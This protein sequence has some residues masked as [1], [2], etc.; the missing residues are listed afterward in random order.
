MAHHV[1]PWW[2]GYW[3]VNPLRRLIENPDALFG[4]LV[5]EGMVVVEPGCG[6]GFFTLSLARLAGPSGRIIA[7]DLQPRML[8]G[9]R[10]R[11]RR[12]RLAD[13][14]EARL[15]TS[16]DLGLSDLAGVA[17]LV[18]AIHVIHEVPDAAGFLGQLRGVLREGGRLLIVEPPGHV[19]AAEFAATCALA[20][21]NGFRALEPPQFG[22]EHV[23]LLAT[24]TP[25]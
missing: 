20:C 17:D 5:R 24:A 10:R 19:S 11:A 7:V 13:R 4:P 23:A 21:T 18:V 6:M 15:A 25:G 9:L 8:A 2:L 3:L 12:K 16:S 1:C 14:I 22:A